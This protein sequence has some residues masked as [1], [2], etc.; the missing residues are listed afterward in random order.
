MPT[1]TYRVPGSQSPHTYELY[2]Q[3]TTIGRSPEN[4]ICIPDPLLE[5]DHAHIQFDGER[6]TISVL[7]R[8]FALSVNGRS[9]RSSTLK[10]NDNIDLG[11]TSFQFRMFSDG[12]AKADEDAQEVDPL[13]AY[14]RIYRF[15][16]ELLRGESMQQLLEKL[17]DQV[18]EVTQAE[19][20]FL[21]LMEGNSPQVAVGRNIQRENLADATQLFS[22]SIVSQV[23]KEQ[24][25]VIVNDALNDENF[26]AAASV[27]NLQ[28]S[29]VMC[30]PLSERGKLLGVM[31]VGN[32]RITSLFDQTS[33]EVLTVF[34]AQASLLLQNAL[35]VNELE[36]DNQK[37]HARLEEMKS[38]GIIGSCEG[39]QRIL[40]KV[41]KVATT[42][43]SV[44]VT[45]ETGT[46]KELIAREIHRRSNRNKGPFV[47]INCGAIPENLLESELFGHVKGAFTGAI[48][49]K[50]GKFQAADGGTLFLDE[51]GEMPLNL[52]VKLLRALE[53]KKVTPVGDTKQ[54]TVD[55][56]IVAAT[57]RDLEVETKENRFREDLYY[58]LNVISL[59]LPPLRE[60]GED[61]N[62]LA[63]FF[64]KRFAAEYNQ[65]V[66]GFTAQSTI[67]LLK[68]HWP[69]NIRELE[70]RVRKA[71]ILSE[72][73]MIDTS[74]LEIREDQM[75]PI[76]PLAEAK[77]RFQSDYIKEVLARNNGNRTKTAR[78]LGVDPRTIF[79]HLEKELE[80]LDEGA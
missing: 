59:H 52:Q 69:G 1:L 8:K 56:R 16:R 51:L 6:F 60:R 70:N 63:R 75:E 32:S 23:V 33:L 65:P 27:V 78:D 25:P 7:Q 3:I 40:N 9:R 22:D 26:S 34:S 5:E 71:V 55:I 43:V 53:E 61:I 45:G 29:S 54:R 28:L 73:T 18:V 15:S 41:R 35:L 47:T 46:G 80:K 20:G 14:R 76:L 77:E 12:T 58:R 67:T 49:D 24:R 62:L 30:V 10:H 57:N 38:S 31:Y 68:Y 13:E 37:L 64:L 19:R 2:K 48:A 79:R 11:G 17:L 36:L 72:G 21:I 4:D 39:I 66:K 44:L 50:M 42:D 74:D